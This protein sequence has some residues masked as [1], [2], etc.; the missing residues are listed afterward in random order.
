MIAGLYELGEPACGGQD[1]VG[2]A[3]PDDVEAVGFR[4]VAKQ[5]F[6]CLVP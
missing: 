5:A 6:R 2:P 3:D 4:V 1:G